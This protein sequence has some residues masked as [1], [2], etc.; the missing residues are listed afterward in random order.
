MKAAGAKLKKAASTAAL[1]D[2]ATMSAAAT[3]SAPPKKPAGLEDLQPVHKA[4]VLKVKAEGAGV[5]SKC[6]WR[7]GCLNCS[8]EKPCSTT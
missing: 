6:R 5:C 4:A 1:K 8:W 3:A 2:L 7:S